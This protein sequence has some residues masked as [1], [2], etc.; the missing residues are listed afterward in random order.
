[1]LLLTT[2]HGNLDF[3][4]FASSFAV[5]EMGEK[6]RNIR[7][8]QNFL[9]R[10][11]YKVCQSSSRLTHES[12]PRPMH[13]IVQMKTIPSH[14]FCISRRWPREWA[15]FGPTHPEPSKKSDFDTLY[16]SSEE[17]TSTASSFAFQPLTPHWV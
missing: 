10:H 8:I 14:A 12:I 6:M 11:L 3:D 1:M 7:I 5:N 13:G 2:L 9:A 4:S 15:G 16:G 17:A